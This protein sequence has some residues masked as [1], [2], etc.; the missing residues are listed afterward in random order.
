M[1]G[2]AAVGAVASVKRSGRSDS[3]RATG[4]NRAPARS[5]QQAGHRI[6]TATGLQSYLPTA[7]AKAPDPVGR[8]AGRGLRIIYIRYPQVRETA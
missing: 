7:K 5:L 4:S 2:V 3:V 8:G 1:S 6:A